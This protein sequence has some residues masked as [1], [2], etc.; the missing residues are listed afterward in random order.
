MA[1]YVVVDMFANYCT[2]GMSKDAVISRAEKQIAR[3][4]R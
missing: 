4:Y 1:E 3:A 2:R